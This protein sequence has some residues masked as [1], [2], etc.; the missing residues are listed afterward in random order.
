MGKLIRWCLFGVLIVWG[1][2]VRA[3][4]D[5]LYYLTP[6]DTIFISIDAYGHKIFEHILA[7]KQTLYAM[8]RFYGLSV[9]ELNFYNPSLDEK[10]LKNGDPVRVPIPNRAIKRYFNEA[11]ENGAFIPVYYVVKKGDTM[12]RISRDFFRM[13]ADT[14]KRRNN[15]WTDEL[16]TGQKLHIGWMNIN[17]IPEEYREG[18]GGPFAKR[19]QA[20]KK[21]FIAQQQTKQTHGQQGVAF[22]DP[23][24]R[25][26][27]DLYALH[28]TAAIDSVIEITNPMR[29][30]TV[31]AKVIG[32]IPDTAYGNNIVVVVSPLTAK[33]LGARDPRF[34]VRIRYLH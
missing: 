11:T 28:R 26:D 15:M 34:F 14:I 7:P 24:S 17:G 19:V 12:Y 1:S 10:T 6:K 22:W 2:Q 23:D 9:S 8:A 13:P 25:E 16:K 18:A 30:R 32:R 33:L 31:Y 29:N 3:T 20:L 5:S 27:S 21:L 4:G